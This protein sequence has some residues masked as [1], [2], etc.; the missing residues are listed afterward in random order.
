MKLS[1]EIRFAQT[2]VRKDR[3]RDWAARAAELEDA[4]EAAIKLLTR[5]GSNRLFAHGGAYFLC[6]DDLKDITKV[7][8]R[9]DGS[10]PKDG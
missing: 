9:L 6:A 1:E 10:L 4:R 2:V 8:G 5:L 3:H 7:I